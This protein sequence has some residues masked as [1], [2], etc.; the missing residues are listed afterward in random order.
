MNTS[1]LTPTA[2][3]DLLLIWR[4]IAKGSVRNADLV[5]EAILE[6]C[7]LA[8]SR[9]VLGHKRNDVSERQIKFLAVRGY[10]SYS[11]AYVEGSEPLRVLRVV[12]GARDVPG[13][14]SGRIVTQ[15]IYRLPAANFF[16]MSRKRRTRSRVRGLPKTTRLSSSGGDMVLPVMI[17]RSSMKFSL[18]LQ[19]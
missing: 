19:V 9:P 5:R 2:R 13:L 6:T 17:A 4:Y 8:A 12:H 3:K 7:D 1:Y 18:T 14:F 16:W 15:V 11:I 10:D